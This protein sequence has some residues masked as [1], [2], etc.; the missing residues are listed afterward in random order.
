MSARLASA[1]RELYGR[2]SQKVSTEQ[3]TLLLAELGEQAPPG[4]A[5]SA[6][7]SEQIR[8]HARAGPEFPLRA[9]PEDV[10]E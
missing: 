2:K 7:S 3:R 1:L 6:L 8:R 10:L 5:G 9:P 4:P